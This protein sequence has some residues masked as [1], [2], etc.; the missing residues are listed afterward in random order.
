MTESVGRSAWH[1]IEVRHLAALQALA[2]EASFHGAARRLGYSQPAV[3][4]QLAALERIVGT[5]LVNRPRV[6]QPLTLTESG[7][8]LLVHARAIQASLSTAEAELAGRAGTTQLRIGAYQSVAAHLLPHVVRELGRKAP[9]VELLLDDCP[10]DVRLVASLDRGDL[11]ACF[12]DLPLRFDR[13]LQKEPLAVDDYV[14]VVPRNGRRAA[15]HE[16]IRPAEL[17]GVK[18]IAFKSSG[19]TQ[20]V[21][22]HL[23]ADGIEPQF[24]LRSDDNNVV[25]G[26]VAA[27]F[28][29]ALIPRL[30]AEL[31]SG[32]L[33]LLPFDPALPPRIIALA[34]TRDLATAPCLQTFVAATLRVAGKIWHDRA[35]AARP[36]A[37]TGG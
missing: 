18:L 29:A 21:I 3:S 9:H 33:D 16:S 11:D 28:G 12:V 20:R 31:L 27:G 10:G 22:D 2:E 8:R 1:G 17:R 13:G 7:E 23:R 35:I 26:F 24:A 30:A 6:S 15:R 25:Q 36:E 32:S 5:Q 14:L 19:S 4:Q 37:V 34:W